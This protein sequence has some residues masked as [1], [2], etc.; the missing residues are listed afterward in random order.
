MI[1]IFDLAWILIRIC[2]FWMAVYGYGYC[3]RKIFGKPAFRA[4]VIFSGIVFLLSIS[5]LLSLLN[6]FTRDV[7]SV[8]IAVGALAGSWFFL[9]YVRRTLKWTGFPGVRTAALLLITGFLLL[10]NLL[11]ASIPDTNPDALTAYAVTPDRWLNNGEITYFEDSILSG[12]PWTGEILSSWPASLST[13]LMDQ[14]SVLQVFQMSML[15]AAAIAAWR[16]LG[17]GF[18]GLLL[19]VSSCMATSMLA[20]WASLPKI[21]MTALFFTTVAIGI[22]LKQY[23]TEDRIFTCIPFLAMGLALAT[24]VTAYVLLPSFLVLV[25]FVPVYRKL[26]LILPAILLMLIPP[27]I[28]AVNT[29]FHTGAPSYPNKLPFF[30]PDP[31]QVLFEVPE[32]K[33]HARANVASNDLLVETEPDRFF[34]NLGRLIESWG[35]PAYI[36]LF[37]LIVALISGKQFRLFVPLGCML[38]YAVISSIAFDPVKWGAKYAFLMSPVLAAA[39]I[40][41][42]KGSFLNRYVF[43]G[44]LIVLLIISSVH[45]RMESLFSYPFFSESIGFNSMDG[46]EVKPLHE[47]CNNNLPDG[48][49]LLSLWKRERYFC[50]HEIIVIEKHPLGLRLFLAP[51]I[52]EEMALLDQMNID[53]VY[54]KS[55]DPM[56]GKLERCINFLYSRRLDPVAEIGGYSLYRIIYKQERFHDPLIQ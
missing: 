5:P 51:S 2:V 45:T 34:T 48:T 14:L 29:Y 35:L 28:F 15:L 7:L 6:L 37:G 12:F 18:N 41:W 20:E 49:R 25:L 26:S 55:D 9:R 50:D 22:L 21:E 3:L 36:F 4:P 44:Y 54:F 38:L 33:A 46:V 13:G 1:R 47:W 40:T 32:I 27:A 39:G 52:G 17:K 43:Y 24:K 42:S 16:L 53:F 8:I 56:P 19:C 30:S 23:L 10:S 11:R 31:E